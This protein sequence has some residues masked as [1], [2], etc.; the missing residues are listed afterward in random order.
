M[1]TKYYAVVCG[2]VPG[3]YTD[4]PT[5]ERMVKGYPGAIFKSFRSRVDAETSLE[6][7]SSW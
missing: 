2:V 5:T 1:G 3:I 6:Y 7:G 4:W